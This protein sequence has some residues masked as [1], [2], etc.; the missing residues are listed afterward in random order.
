M[1]IK[2]I[3][4]LQDGENFNPLTYKK[5]DSLDA[6][7]VGE[8]T[9]D[10]AT[11]RITSC[12]AVEINLCSNPATTSQEFKNF[13]SNFEEDFYCREYLVTTYFEYLYP[14]FFD[15]EIEFPS[16]LLDWCATNMKTDDEPIIILLDDYLEDGSF[17]SIKKNE[18]G[19]IVDYC[20]TDGEKVQTDSFW[21]MDYEEDP[22]LK[23]FPKSCG[24]SSELRP[25]ISFE[26]MPEINKG[27]P[28]S[29]QYHTTFDKADDA[30][31]FLKDVLKDG[32]L[33]E[34]IGHERGGLWLSMDE[35]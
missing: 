5:D 25:S 2:T 8:N 17:L 34:D 29:L 22:S 1:T 3:N 6:L 13:I 15:G 21:F 26:P 30:L 35:L 28:F 4:L 7:F 31:D 32:V 18:E 16:S 11:V 19:V 27:M 33:W 24:L 9:N 14:F 20:S 12:N 10:I 23:V